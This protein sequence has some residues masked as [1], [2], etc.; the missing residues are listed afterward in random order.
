[1]RVPDVHHWTLTVHV[2]QKIHNCTQAT[3]LEREIKTPTMQ[4]RIQTRFAGRGHK[5]ENFKYKF[6]LCKAVKEEL[7]KTL[8]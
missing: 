8:M 1:M 4:L 7:R 6:D 5:F 2:T 3:N